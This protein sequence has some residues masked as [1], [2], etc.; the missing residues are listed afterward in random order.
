MMSM[1]RCARGV[2]ETYGGG[3]DRRQ[4]PVGDEKRGRTVVH[5]AAAERR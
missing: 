4:R 3:L 1:R 2:Q 5:L